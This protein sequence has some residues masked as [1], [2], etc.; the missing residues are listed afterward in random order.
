MDFKIYYATN[1]GHEGA[2]RFSPDRYGERFSSDGMENLRFGRVTFTADEQRVNELLN[3]DRPLT[4]PG[5]GEAL[6]D[7]FAACAKATQRIEAYE[8][9]IPDPR[10]SD[11][12][13]PTRLGSKAMF[14]DLQQDMCVGRDM[15][16]LI[17]GYNVDWEEAV[18]TAAALEATLNRPDP[19]PSGSSDHSVA[20]TQPV[21]V[22]LFTWP[23][24]GQALPF[25]SYKSDRSDAAA[26]AGAVGRGLLKVRDFLHEL[27]RELRKSNVE[28]AALRVQLESQGV[29]PSEVHRAIAQLEAMRIC[30]QNIHLL[31]HS[32]GNYVLQH[33]LARVCEFTPG[34]TMPRLFDRVFLCA[35]DVDDDVLEPGKPMEPVHQIANLVAIYHNPNDNAL[36]VSDYTKGN[37]D[38]LGH[39][40][41]ARP[42]SLHHKMMQVDCNAL[43]TGWTQHSYY[44]N[45]RIA[46]DIRL[47]L[48][49]I[50]PDDP[51]RRLT[52]VAG[53]AAN[54]WR[55]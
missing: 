48:Q 39:R 36:R 2:D 38:R 3:Q 7:Y 6:Q 9:S 22:V 5:D 52:R 43:V 27:G 16:V 35:A 44:T 47:S 21:R 31:A 42:Q 23:S 32:M 33:A 45:G 13:Q 10:L 49:G 8:E 4:G 29:R 41:A 51:A 55:F 46:R 1:R 18:G 54:A 20:P 50:A 25:V 40:G 37:P 14:A 12:A 30:G 17:H 28:A 26:S 53:S 24:N 11:T 34:D 15:L 19:A